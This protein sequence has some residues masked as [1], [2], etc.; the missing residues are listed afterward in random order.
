MSRIPIQIADSCT[1]ADYF[2][3]PYD[4]EDVVAYFGYALQMASL[5]LPQ[6]TGELD[7]LQDLHDRI[8]ETLPFISLSNETTRREILIAPILV[9]VIHYAQAKLKIGYTLKATE[10]LRGELDYYF[11]ATTN[12]L[13]IEAKQADLQKGFTQLATELIAL[14]LLTDSPDILHGAVSTG[15][16]WQFGKLDRATKIITQDLNLYRV[17][18]DLEDILR[19][20]IS[21]LR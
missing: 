8:T 14:E 2:K 13:I 20:L 4:T 16:I 1:F 6:A 15:N 7:R 9:D 11:E 12:L 3:L 21:L 19:I 17:P 10:Q 5:S 18:T